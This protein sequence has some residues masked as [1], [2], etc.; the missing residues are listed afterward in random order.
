MQNRIFR[1]CW[2]ILAVALVLVSSAKAQTACEVNYQITSQT[3]GSFTAGI[4]IYN[5][6]TTAVSSWK[7][8]WTFANGQKVTKS[9]NS[10]YKQ[11]RS[12]V[13]LSSVSSDG[14]IPA[15]GSVT[16]VSIT[17]SWNNV[18]NSVPTAFTLNGVAC[19]IGTPTTGVAVNVN[20][21]ANRHFISPYIYGGNGFT[22]V[23]Q[24]S[25]LGLP[26]VRWGGNAT[27]DYNWQLHTYNSG[28]D[29]YFE[30]FGLGGSEPDSVQFITDAQSG[31]A[32]PLTTM[33]MLPWVAQSGENGTNGHWSYSIATFGAQC[34]HDPYNTDAGNGQKTD[35]ST[36][37]TTNP[38]TTAYFPLLDSSSQSCPTGNCVYRQPW[39]QA[40]ATAFGS[41]KVCPVPNS[42]ITSCHFYDMDNEPDIWSG[43]HRDVHPT[44]SGYDELANTYE[45][46]ASALKT[47]DPAAVR[48]GPVSCCWWF[49]WNIGP[50]GD[51]KTAH[52]GVDF[53][54]WFL[55]QTYW[56]DQ[57]NGS[58]TLDVF[59]IHAYPDANTSGLTTAQL[60]ALS[61]DVYRDYWDPTYVSTSGTVNQNW[62]TQIQPN[63]TIPFRIPRMK[64]MVNAI[65]PGTPLSFTE[66]SAAFYQE[67]DFSTAL[68]DADALGIM[69]REGLSFSSR[70]GA[71]TTGNPNYQAF[72]LYTNYDGAHHGFNPVSA[73]A[74]NN[75]DPNLF[76]SYAAINSAGNGMTIMVINKDPGNAAQVNFNLNGFSASTYIA[77][78]ISSANS[79]SIQASALQAWNS[80]QSF[81]PYSITLL[82][83]NGTEVSVPASEW[84]LNPDDLMIPAGG[85]ATLHPSI[86]SGSS[87]VTL[88]SAVFDSFEGASAC[89]GTLSITSA[90]VTPTQPG[91][92]AV[93]APATSGF[94]HYTVTASVGS[95][96]QTQGGWIV[97]GN[98][99]ATLTSTGSGQSGTRGTTLSQPLTITL[100]PRS[101][102]GSAVGAG[103]F[104]TASAGTLSNG[105]SS[106]SKV[107]AITNASGVVSVTL[108]LPSS[109]GTVT[110]TAQDQFAVGGATSS[111]T[112]TAQ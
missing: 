36:P 23:S 27:S 102:G 32:S 57:I 48:F 15:G 80:S 49:Y 109:P 40:L 79:T 47:W 72:K 111:F 66:W 46:E 75:G 18:T 44:A 70:W 6:G 95:V 62:A 39:A 67:A 68:G 10:T 3:S 86:A 55:N 96:Q 64:A 81:A 110:V 4:A 83:I 106:G 78:S 89:S 97:V 104:F 60:Q 84:S 53:L 103:I 85:S 2:M 65:Y 77:Y 9:V 74:T 98:P 87:N 105:T 50:A 43:S 28:G 14:S 112:E 101:S 22:S 59:D 20:V 88:S 8:A 17:G 99:P 25:D 71:P 41:T 24:L 16:G 42:A 54:P 12:N 100:N 19:K 7:L 5:I 11:T 94:C 52:G 90:T 107:I 108:T 63:K 56:H 91:A 34:S 1:T 61:A 51:D 37:V 82:V 76:S 58:R 35:C 92:I 29:W 73:S 21:Q 69:G 33:A 30:D 26:F 38:V 93:T 45:A 13:T 31:G